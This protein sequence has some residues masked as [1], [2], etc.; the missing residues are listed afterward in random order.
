[1]KPSSV[2]LAKRSRQATNVTFEAELLAA[3]RALKINVS[4]AAESG[5]ARA[6]ATRQAE[7]WLAANRDA[8]ESSNA[9]VDKHGLPLARFRAF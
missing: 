9:Y 5:L 1:M 8:L 7:L 4:Q 3:A 6:V 2:V